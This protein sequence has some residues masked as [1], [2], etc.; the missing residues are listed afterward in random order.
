MTIL[1]LRHS[2]VTALLFAMASPAIAETFVL[3]NGEVIEGAVIRSI[4]RTVSISYVGAGMVQLPIGAVQ[5]VEIATTDGGVISGRLISWSDGTYRLS[6]D[7]GEVAVS[8]ENGVAVAV[9]GE[10]DDGSATAAPVAAEESPPETDPAATTAD[11]SSI[12]AGFIYAG[13]IDDG[14]RTFMH[15]KGR[16]S[17]A[18]N[19]LVDDTMVLEISSEDGNQAES[20]V[21]QLVA[22]GANVVFMTGHNSAASITSSAKRHDDVRFVHCGA[23]A[24]SRNIEVVCGRIYQ[25]RYL[26]GMIAGGMTETGLIGY[27]A[28]EP[29]PETIMGINAFTLGVQSIRPDARIVVH[30]TQSWFA[31]GEE[32]RRAEELADRGVDVLTI[33]QDSP[34]ALQVAERRGI[35]AIGFQNDMSAFAPSVTLTS[36]VWNWGKMYDQII[37]QL[38]GAD[39]QLRPTWLGLRDGVVDLAPISDRVPNELQRLVRQRQREIIDG[40][41]NVFTGP[42]RDIDGDIRVPDGRIMTDESLLSMDYLIDGVVGY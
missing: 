3:A 9:L 19:P 5:Q 14:G 27:I 37:D 24:P 13:P 29:L 30:W 23:F 40:R 36:A 39:V 21:D 4:G 7:Q 25:A 22:D 16:L 28:A 42:I 32:Q 11:L 33:H 26:S 17:L 34:A 38:N 31:P 41:F 1:S 18:A 8:V 12:T 6:T 2:M 20:A 10:G 15:E 35:D